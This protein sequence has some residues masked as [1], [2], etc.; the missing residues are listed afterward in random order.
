MKDWK[1]ILE[2]L[3]LYIIIMI[4]SSGLFHKLTELHVLFSLP[5]SWKIMKNKSSHMAKNLSFFSIRGGLCVV[6]YYI[7]SK[8]RG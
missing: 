2:L 7:H 5:F 6:V 1:F 3:W 4:V 8:M